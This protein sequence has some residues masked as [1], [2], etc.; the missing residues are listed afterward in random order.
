[1]YGKELHEYSASRSGATSVARGTKCVSPPHWRVLR[2]FCP[3][4]HLP[5]VKTVYNLLG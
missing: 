4:M 3:K 1:M 5:Q 2:S